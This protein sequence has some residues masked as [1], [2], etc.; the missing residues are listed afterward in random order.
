MKKIFF[1]LIS[2]FIII[3]TGC[4]K[5]EYSI[6]A[7][8]LDDEKFNYVEIYDEENESNSILCNYVKSVWGGNTNPYDVHDTII[9]YSY[10]CDTN[11]TYKIK[12]NIPEDN[13]IKITGVTEY[14]FNNFDYSDHDLSRDI[15]YKENDDNTI[16]LDVSYV[17]Y[18]NT[19]VYQYYK[20]NFKVDKI[21][22]GYFYFGVSYGNELTKL[23]KTYDF[24][25]DIT[26][27]KLEYLL[28]KIEDREIEVSASSI[29][30]SVVNIINT[31][32]L[33]KLDFTEYTFSN[34]VEFEFKLVDESSTHNIKVD[35]HLVSYY[36]GIYYQIISQDNALKSIINNYTK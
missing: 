6:I 17:E 15:D 35:T 36:N 12:V 13:K 7:K 16:T 2:F 30:D 21:H 19:H 18:N 8:E 27:S 22:Y 31:L 1:V 24:L 25:T 5:K 29:Q 3:L 10:L 20:I 4:T 23:K 32:Y 28:L 34:Y 26:E 9:R 14:Y 33:V 11:K